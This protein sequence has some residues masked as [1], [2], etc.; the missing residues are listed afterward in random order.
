MCS[1]VLWSKFRDG[2]QWSAAANRF[3]RSRL[4]AS[5][6]LTS[7]D[8]SLLESVLSLR[9]TNH[10]QLIIPAPSQRI[11]PISAKFLS[12]TQS[13]NKVSHLEFDLLGS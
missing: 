5:L 2:S 9:D 12:L 11:G 4:R 7:P 1:V 3:F 6:L 10:E 8:A 13:A